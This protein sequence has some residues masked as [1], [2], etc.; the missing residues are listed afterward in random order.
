MLKVS[1]VLLAIYDRVREE[2]GALKRNFTLQGKFRKLTKKLLGWKIKLFH[3]FSLSAKDS[4][5]NI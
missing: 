5:R 2:K 1:I 4:Q 3:I